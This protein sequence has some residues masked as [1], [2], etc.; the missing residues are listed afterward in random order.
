MAS[1]SDI[2][3]SDY[4]RLLLAKTLIVLGILALGAR[5]RRNVIAQAAPSRG[6][7]RTEL[8]LA[9]LVLIVTA[10]LTGTAPPGE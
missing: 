3:S 1:I 8:A 7:V 4:G 6:S 2:V 10:V 9:A 5:H